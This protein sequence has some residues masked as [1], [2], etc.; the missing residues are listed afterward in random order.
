MLMAEQM[1]SIPSAL[2]LQPKSLLAAFPSAL[3][4]PEL[5]HRITQLNAHTEE[6]IDPKLPIKVTGGEQNQTKSDSMI[7]Q[8]ANLTPRVRSVLHMTVAMALHFGGYEFFRN[9]CLALFTSSEYGF[10]SAAAFPMANAMVSP[11]SL[12]LLLGYGQQLDAKG[13]RAALRNTTILSIVFIAFASASLHFCKA[14]GLPQMVGQALIGVTFLFQNSYQ[15]LLYSQYWSFVGSVLTPDEG[16]RWFATLGGFSSVICSLMGGCVPFLL[17][18][19]GLYGLM[20]STCVALVVCL[21]CSDRAYALAQQHH[22][23]PAEQIKK[24]SSKSSEEDAGSENGRLGKAIGL[25]KRVPTL[26]ALFC[27]VLS[28]QSLNTILGVAFITALKT[29]IADDMARSAYTGRFYSYI[30][31]ASA[32][33]QFLV[34]PTFMKYAEPKWIW[35]LMPVIPLVVCFL[36]M[37]Q[38]DLSLTLLAT[39]MFLAKLMDYS[40]RTVVYVMVYQPLDFESRYMGKEIISV[41][42]SRFGKSG[43]SL[44]LTGFT[45]LGFTSLRGLCRL[46]FGAVALW[47]CS[48]I[49]LSGFLP[50]QKEAQAAAEE[51]REEAKKTK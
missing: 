15:Y 40:I 20:A 33:L 26:G 7:N 30:N 16:S 14:A 2:L 23:D 28:W 38:A 34:L 46:S 31:G 44:I 21:L 35:R 42:G 43:M 29:N 8:L 50:T 11:F 5:A 10:S 32:L 41:F 13:P 47:Q 37:F 12:I 22:F 25:F 4:L 6:G 9:S 51:Q 24:K 45:A 49:W 36:L 27:E 1:S 48:T 18:H 19:T 3:I 17:P 39:A